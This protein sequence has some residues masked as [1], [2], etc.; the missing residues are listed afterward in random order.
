M[1]WPPSA[2]TVTCRTADPPGSARSSATVRSRSRAP[3][4]SAAVRQ[5]ACG[6][7]FF[8]GLKHLPSTVSIRSDFWAVQDQKFPSAAPIPSG[9]AA[10]G[11]PAASSMFLR[12]PRRR[13][14]THVT[15]CGMRT[16]RNTTS[17][18]GSVKP[19]V[20]RIANEIA[21]SACG[22]VSAGCGD[23]P[24]TGSGE[25]TADLA[26]GSIEEHE[27]QDQRT[28][29]DR[30]T[31]NAFRSTQPSTAAP[32]PRDHRR[33]SGRTAL[34]R[35]GPQSDVRS[36][37]AGTREIP[38]SDDVDDSQYH[39]RHPSQARGSDF[40]IASSGSSRSAANAVRGRRARLAGD[41]PDSTCRPRHRRRGAE[42]VPF[43]SIP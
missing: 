30:G 40:L 15:T 17:E 25:P 29:P 23:G 37:L 3:P 32:E 2:T 43:L 7:I 6:N 20:R 26:L 14:V 18:G 19:T 8:R 24:G 31:I 27:T 42:A 22:G 9:S 39:G 38:Q 34:A 4:A 33:L 11:S 16:I 13:A 5:A 12:P 1:R 21:P 35:H 28:H 10:G 36:A 41:R